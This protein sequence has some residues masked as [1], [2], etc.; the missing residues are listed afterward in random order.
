[1]NAIVEEWM[2][3]LKSTVILNIWQVVG[4]WLSVIKFSEEKAFSDET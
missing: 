2:Y 4:F 1:M 3:E